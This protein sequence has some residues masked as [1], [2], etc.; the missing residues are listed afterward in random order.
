MTRESREA[1][2][3]FA[4]PTFGTTW[5]GAGVATELYDCPW[6]GSAQSIEHGLCQVCLM[7]FPVETK[8]IELA[9]V[10]AARASHPSTTKTNAAV[11]D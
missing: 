3:T 1:R 2:A 7:E 11:P 5:K 10:R 6:C 9:P 8:I 4:A